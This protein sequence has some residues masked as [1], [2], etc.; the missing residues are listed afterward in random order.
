LAWLA[1]KQ[2]GGSR[3]PE[4]LEIFCEESPIKTLVPARFEPLASK[5]AP[6]L[7]KAVSPGLPAHEQVP[8]HGQQQ[9]RLAVTEIQA[10]RTKAQAG[11]NAGRQRMDE[12]AKK[13]KTI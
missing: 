4:S 12:D 2:Q 9:A 8:L 10:D 13:P 11:N 1:K 3:R 7:L 6:P 5:V